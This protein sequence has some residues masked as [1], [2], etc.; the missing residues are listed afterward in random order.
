MSKK[1]D[2]GE[3]GEREGGKRGKTILIPTIRR[4]RPEDPTFESS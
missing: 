1:R 3:R 2:R 4:M